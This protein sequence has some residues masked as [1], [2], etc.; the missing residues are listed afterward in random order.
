M[1]PK[2]KL[3][4]HARKMLL[5]WMRKLA[6]P[7]R[8][9]TKISTH[10]MD[11]PK[12]QAKPLTADKIHPLVSL[13]ILLANS[14]MATLLFSSLLEQDGCGYGGTGIKRSACYVSL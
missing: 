13:S 12:T 7:G 2:L 4:E 1:T 10:M 8:R 5:S 14:F 3:S 6:L 11:A 9:R